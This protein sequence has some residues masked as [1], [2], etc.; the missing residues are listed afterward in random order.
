MNRPNS[1]SVRRPKTLGTGVVN[2]RKGAAI[3]M[4]RLEFDISRLEQAIAQAEQRA[5][6]AR[7]EL[8]TQI[9]ERNKIAS[10]LRD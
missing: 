9:A 1:I 10:F 3:Q 8:A 6:L 2:N 5:A 4:V 7:A